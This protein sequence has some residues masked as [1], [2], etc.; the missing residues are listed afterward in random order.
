[1]YL[2]RSDLEKKKAVEINVPH[3][4]RM[5]CLNE[6]TLNPFSEL[7]TEIV[8]K[9][10]E[11]PFNRYFNNITEELFAKLAKYA[12]VSPK[13]IIFG[14]GADEMIYTV[15][16]AVRDN[17]DSFAVALAPSY[18]D[19]K[20]YSSAVGLGMKFLDLDSD[21]QFDSAEFLKLMD[22]ENCKLGVLCNPNNPTGNMIP[23]EKIEAVLQG[24]DKLIMLDETYFEFSGVTW[25][26]RLSEYPNLIIIRSFSKAFSSAGLRFGYIISTPENIVELNKVMTIFHMN[27]MTQSIVT[28]ILDN[29]DL[30]LN[31]N[32]IVKQEKEFIYKELKKVPGLTIRDTST[33]FL[34][35]NIG[36]DTLQLFDY[37]AEKEIALRNVSAHPIMKNMIRV[38]IGSKEDNREFLKELHKFMETR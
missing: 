12:E 7:Q 20:S 28:V 11:V 1:M 34:I 4:K 36:N 2:F 5:M 27:L 33:N 35:F 23:Q 18:F 32:E 19:Y 37:L 25:K 9:L 24:T 13:N 22:D 15:F 21:F 10:K 38:T 14:N 31:H 8:K 26:D 30:F 29:K 6:S 3:K 17:P 16:T